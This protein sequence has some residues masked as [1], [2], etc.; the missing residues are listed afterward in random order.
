MEVRR[1]ISFGFLRLMLGG[2]DVMWFV[3]RNLDMAWSSLTLKWTRLAGCYKR[4][5]I[6]RVRQKG[7]P[8]NPKTVCTICINWRTNSHQRTS[9]ALRCESSEHNNWAWWGVIDLGTGRNLTRLGRASELIRWNEFS[10]L[11]QAHV[12][13]FFGCQLVAR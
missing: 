5:K 11:I 4:V 9:A 6:F 1:L 12:E 10:I 2:I 13:N 7:K 8:S 3:E